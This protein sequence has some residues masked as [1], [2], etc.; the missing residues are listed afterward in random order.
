MQVFN[1]HLLLVQKIKDEGSWEPPPLCQAALLNHQSNSPLRF[2]HNCIQT[3]SFMSSKK[4]QRKCL[5]KFKLSSSR[6]VDMERGTN[7]V[8]AKL[9]LQ[10]SFFWRKHCG[11]AQDDW[12]WNRQGSRNRLKYNLSSLIWKYGGPKPQ[13]Q[14]KSVVLRSA[15]IFLLHL[16]FFSTD[17]DSKLQCGVFFFNKSCVLG[18]FPPPEMPCLLWFQNTLSKPPGRDAVCHFPA[19]VWRESSYSSCSANWAVIGKAIGTYR[20]VGVNEDAL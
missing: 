10:V 8:S 1:I 3:I 5:C 9:W 2:S 17:I 18:T 13:P 14:Q 12:K 16:C 20:I 19:R 6:S 4:V 15:C 7:K 11:F